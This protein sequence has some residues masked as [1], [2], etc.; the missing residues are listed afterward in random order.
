LTFSEPNLKCRIAAATSSFAFHFPQLLDDVVLNCP[1]VLGARVAAVILPAFP[2]EV[3]L[4]ARRR[5]GLEAGDAPEAFLQLVL[6]DLGGLL[7]DLLQ[8]SRK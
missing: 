3:G 4:V 7:A 5:V 1:L 6:C 8:G 2:N